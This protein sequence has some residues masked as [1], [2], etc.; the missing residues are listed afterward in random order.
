VRPRLLFVVLAASC[1]VLGG[2]GG[3]A[4]GE[5]EPT[6]GY[7]AAAE[8]LAA[9]SVS[10]ATLARAR[11][12]VDALLARGG[13]AATR[14]RAGRAHAVLLALGEAGFLAAGER[15]AAGAPD[16]L[17]EARLLPIVAAAENPA[18]DAFLRVAAAAPDP[19]PRLIAAD[20]L[21]WNRTA[22]A[23]PALVALAR[24]PVPGVRVAA[25]RGLFAIDDD[26]AVEARHALPLDPRP[27]LAARRLAWH[28]T[29]GHAAP[30]LLPLAEDAYEH[31]RSPDE[32][33]EGA[34]LLTEAA[35]RAPLPLARRIVE[36]FGSDAAGA[37]LG[38]VR[39]GA[40][41]GPYEPVRARRIAIRANW[42][43][44]FRGD[45]DQKRDA[46]DRAVGWIANPV[47]VDAFD[48][49][50]APEMVLRMVL[51][52]VGE[53]LVA[54]T[55][56]RLL[57]GRFADP[58]EGVFLLTEALSPDAAA[59]HLGTILKAGPA[60]PTAF[61]VAAWP[62]SVAWGTRR[63]PTSR[64]IRRRAPSCAARSCARSRGSRRRG[65]S[66]T[67]RRCCTARIWISTRPRSN[68]WRSATG[69]RRDASSRRT[70]SATRPTAT[71]E[72]STS[73]SPA[74]TSPTKCWSTPWRTRGSGCGRRRS[75]SWVT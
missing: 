72:C 16:A 55:V 64:P 22:A 21:A 33:V 25:L 10:P 58:Q 67:W 17:A 69:R 32:R 31:G 29:R 73:W 23:L 28:T 7:A 57:A 53:A 68:P 18:A 15:L 54:P 74:T 37:V 63:S 1:G 47:R 51:P 13:D 39:S 75:R 38:R 48:E 14:E 2:V 34:R 35:V 60:V 49:R 65:P 4:G 43:A 46:I 36:E 19:A 71:R 70:S 52:D 42:A 41:E 3:A 11:E 61:R 45:D 30:D 62:T 12:A 40:P 5:V 27:D 50:P 24:D 8:A 6:P 59:R 9:L 56:R 20:G 44:V 26:G 66:T